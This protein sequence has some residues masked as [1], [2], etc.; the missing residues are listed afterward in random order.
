LNPGPDS[1]YLLFTVEVDQ[2]LADRV[3]GHDGFMKE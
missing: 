3:L 2:M 1:F